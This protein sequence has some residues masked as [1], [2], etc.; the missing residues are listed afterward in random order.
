MAKLIKLS[1]AAQLLGVSPEQLTDMR[2]R[3]EIFGYRDGSTWKFKLEEL[4]RVK[5]ERGVGAKPAGQQPPASDA[6]DE[7]DE[8]DELVDVGD[9]SL[10]AD[11]LDIDLDLGSGIKLQGDADVIEDLGGDDSDSILVSDEELGQ[12]DENTASTIIGEA[13][14]LLPQDSGLAGSDALAEASDLEISLDTS[15]SASDILDQDRDRPPSASDTANLQVA[16]SSDIG[17]S[18]KLQDSGSLRISQDDSSVGGSRIELVDDTIEASSSGFGSAIDLGLDDDD[19]L[20]LGS[21]TG[22]DVTSGA[23]DSGIS[24]GNPSD[25]GL[26]LEEPLDLSSGS[27]GEALELGEDES[28]SLDLPSG[29]ASDDDFMLTPVEE[30]LDEESDSGSQVIALDSSD[31]DEDSAVE[32]LTEADEGLGA[33]VAEFEPVEAA[34]GTPAVAAVAAGRAEAA[35]VAP[36]DEQAEDYTVWNVL[37]LFSIV[38][39]LGFTGILMLDLVSNIW[40][41]EGN[42]S[43][44]STIM[45]AILGMMP[46]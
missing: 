4:E 45:D 30:S 43:A 11:D 16:S 35:A 40:S 13:D 18:V 9:L 42:L 39:L 6:V 34:A 29:D 23:G 8:M 2:S 38:L 33:E 25:S 26:S 7:V 36:A 14:D 46:G 12:S 24:L 19:D 17:D 5:A 37:S 32:M 3:N 27:A 44:S 21:G 41:W 22:S 10:E 15:P 20:V 31:F 28:L 1:E